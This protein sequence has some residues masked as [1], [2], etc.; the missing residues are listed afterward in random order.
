MGINW[1]NLITR[2]PDTGAYRTLSADLLS[3]AYLV[4]KQNAL[5]WDTVLSEPNSPWA[6]SFDVAPVPVRHA[7]ESAF[8][9]LIC[10]TRNGNLDSII[11]TDLPAGRAQLHLRGLLDVGHGLGGLPEDFA[12]IRHVLEG[13]KSLEAFPMCSPPRGEFDSVLEEAL[14]AHLSTMHGVAPS[15][16]EEPFAS[17]LTGTAL[18][19]VQET[20]VSSDS[21]RVAI[22]DSLSFYAARDSGE[23]AEFAAGI[24]HQLIADGSLPQDIAVLIP[25]AGYGA[26]LV[27]DEFEK[28][29][30]LLCGVPDPTLRDTASETLWLLLH[31]MRKGSSTMTLASLCLLPDMPWSDE[32]GIKM[33]RSIIG[34]RTR[35]TLPGW[36]NNIIGAAPRNYRALMSQLWE[37]VKELPSIKENVGQV[38]ALAPSDMSVPVDWDALFQAIRP[39]DVSGEASER[40]VEAS[41]LW[42]GTSE[43]WRPAKHLIILGFSGSSYPRKAGVGPVFLDSELMQIRDLCGLQMP[44]RAEQMKR[45][46]SLFQRQIGAVSHSVTFLSPK[47]DLS[48]K[49]LG[50]TAAL[51]LVARTLEQMEDGPEALVK[52]ARTLPPSEWPCVSHLINQEPLSTPVFPTGDKLDLKRDVLSLRRDDAGLMKSQSPSRLETMLVSPLVWVMSE[53]GANQLDWA[54][55]SMSAMVQGSLYH[56]VLEHL[57]LPGRAVPNESELAAGFDAAFDKAVRSEARFLLNEVWSVEHAHHRSE[58]FKM[59]SSWRTRLEQ[60]GVKIIANEQSLSGEALGIWLRGIADSVL[61]FPDGQKLVV[62]F[63]ASQ[64]GVRRK[65]MEAGWDIQV[66]LYRHMIANPNNVETVAIGSG[67]ADPAIAYHLLRDGVTLGSGLRKPVPEIEVITGDI[68]GLAMERLTRTLDE[69][70]QGVIQLNRSSD[71]T[72]FEKET[73]ITPYALKDNPLGAAF[74][75]PDGEV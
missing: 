62:D 12:V 54:P 41:S 32:R 73:G 59:A 56:A 11:E 70:K 5:D 6:A 61:E 14:H 30:I 48:G 1:S 23:E 20:L 18:R 13:H 38:A 51:S 45:N 65:R 58:A 22:D 39:E 40:F 67:G 42:I 2:N 7:V 4:P 43:P 60:M 24:A 25:D 74:M 19:H 49:K 71:V 31:A 44:T 28:A 26:D 35:D 66:A 46:L 72:F 17:G 10:A 36:L 29:G 47:Q 69:L 64:S 63:K 68:S 8:Q 16:N 55:E 50:P 9:D 53:A 52:D 33:A 34:G 27:K 15:P 75:L 37:L 57:F 21:D 3:Q